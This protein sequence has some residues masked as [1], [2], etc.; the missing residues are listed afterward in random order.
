MTNTKKLSKGFFWSIIEILLKRIFDFGVKFLLASLLF[1]EEFGI[2]GMATVFTSFL[3]LMSEVGIGA[4]LVQRKDDELSN[5]HLNTTFWS[6]IVWAIFLYAFVYFLITPLVAG[7]YE[8]PQLNMV[9]PLLS[10]PILFSS[11]N[12]IHNAQLLRNL[13]FKKLAIINNTGTFIAGIGAIFLALTGYGIW[14]L[15]F[16]VVVPFI[17]KMPLFFYAT[18]WLPKLEWNKKAFNDIFL[19]GLFTLGT[20]LVNNF[21]N[22]IDYL[23]IGKMINAEILGAYTL[24]FM[25]TSLVR[26]QL[27]SMLNRVLFPFYSKLQDEIKKLKKYFLKMIQYYALVIYPIMACLIVLGDELVPYFFGDKWDATILPLKILAFAVIIDVFTISYYLLYRSMGK[28]KQELK[29]QLF[30]SLI[31]YAP[32]VVVGVYHNGI[33]GAAYGILIARLISF[34]VI[35]FMLN[36]LFQLTFIELFN[37]IKKVVLVNAGIGVIMFLLFKYIELHVLLELTFFILSYCLAII[38]FFKKDIVAMKVRFLKR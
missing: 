8:E 15:I 27:A 4:A 26:A 17:I 16:N 33:V 2:I 37:A 30:I 23:I 14:A 25:L 38:L 19:F 29:I 12:V 24:A 21:S 28:P 3:I 22:N 34:F 1:P 7:F 13:D 35:M 10:L 6:G 36:K 9:V 11:I 20:V 31:I 32:S 18:K 5:L